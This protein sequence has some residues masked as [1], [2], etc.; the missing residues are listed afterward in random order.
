MSGIYAI[1][2]Q[3]YIGD[4]AIPRC[5]IDE[6]P[7]TKVP[8]IQRTDCMLTVNYTLPKLPR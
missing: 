7:R 8:C 2:T 6:G 5:D 4:L 3:F 1:T